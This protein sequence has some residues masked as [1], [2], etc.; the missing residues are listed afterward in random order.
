M[1]R[2]LWRWTLV[3]LSFSA[4]LLGLFALHAGRYDVSRTGNGV[5]LD[6]MLVWDRWKH[7][8]VVPIGDS[9]YSLEDLTQPQ[10]AAA[11]SSSNT[12]E[13]DCELALA[14]SRLTQEPPPARCTGTAPR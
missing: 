9:I 13:L 14:L 3:V 8:W 4:L 7:R 12:D 6:A 10:A 11:P 1:E 5:G 2:L